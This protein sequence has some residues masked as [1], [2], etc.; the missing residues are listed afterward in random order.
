VGEDDPQFTEYEFQL[1]IKSTGVKYVWS[2]ATLLGAF[3]KIGGILALLKFISIFM[4]FTHEF[5]FLKELNRFE[6]EKSSEKSNFREVYSF[7]K[8]RELLTVI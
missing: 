6:S 8:M 3:V 1:T 4:S 2:P 7:A 5:L